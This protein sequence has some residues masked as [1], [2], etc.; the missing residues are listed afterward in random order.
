MPKILRV[1]E[2][3]PQW[4]HL[5][6]D[7]S[8]GC[9]VIDDSDSDRPDIGRKLTFYVN[10][11]NSAFKTDLKSSR[12][13]PAVTEEK[14]VLANVIVG[15]GIL[16]DSRPDRENGTEPTESRE[17]RV[18]STTR[19]LAPFL[20]PMINSLGSLSPDDVSALARVGDDD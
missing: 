2:D 15:L 5:S 16:N 4:R 7:D 1:K 6:F 11:S 14:F 3:D 9:K 12:E 17:E 10:T 18:A 20:L 19:A 13:A 8:T